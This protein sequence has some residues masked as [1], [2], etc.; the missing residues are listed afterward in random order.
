MGLSSRVCRVICR[1]R[2]GRIDLTQ[3]KL[4]AVFGSG[5]AC[6]DEMNRLGQTDPN[7]LMDGGQEYCATDDH[8]ADGGWR[9]VVN[10]RCRSRLT[11]PGGSSQTLQTGRTVCALS[12]RSSTTGPNRVFRS[13][14]PAVWNICTGAARHRPGLFLPL[15]NDDTTAF[16]RARDRAPTRRRARSPGSSSCGA[17]RAARMKAAMPGCTIRRAR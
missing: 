5:K 1:Q 14:D 7:A 4:A 16:S 9:F 11:K 6:R 10:R 8:A 3:S 15:R 2:S 13:A 12:P 17:R